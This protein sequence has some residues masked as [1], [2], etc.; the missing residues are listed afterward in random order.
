M[1]GLGAGY[2]QTI[3]EVLDQYSLTPAQRATVFSQVESSPCPWFSRI[4][5]MRAHEFA[6]P[7]RRANSASA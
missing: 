2:A 6:A 3:N 1:T 7:A 4:A 5:Y